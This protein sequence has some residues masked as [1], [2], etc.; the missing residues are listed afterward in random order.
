[1]IALIGELRIGINHEREDRLRPT[2]PSGGSAALPGLR[3]LTELRQECSQRQTSPILQRS[4]ANRNDV[5]S[6]LRGTTT[7]RKRGTRTRKDRDDRWCPP[8]RASLDDSGTRLLAA[9]ATTASREL[10]SSS[11][12][13][14]SSSM[15]TRLVDQAS[16]LSNVSGQVLL[17]A[18]QRCR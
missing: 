2:L 3:Q 15:P 12:F 8:G 18:F 11:G 13:P 14:Y 7:V 10:W 1:M 16:S 6:P 4:R 17:H 9:A 5:A